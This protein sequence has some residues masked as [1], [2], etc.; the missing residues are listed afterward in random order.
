[1]H[2]ITAQIKE[3]GGEWRGG[4]M[5]G[6]GSLGNIIKG[7]DEEQE[8]VNRSSRGRN[9]EGG[10]GEEVKEIRSRVK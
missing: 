4:G 3:G 9:M 5:E 1:M 10:R 8:N 7:R 6:N 2:E